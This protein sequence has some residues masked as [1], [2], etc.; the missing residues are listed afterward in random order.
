MTPSRTSPKTENLQHK[1]LAAFVTEAANYRHGK[2]GTN[3]GNVVEHGEKKR[4]WRKTPAD[5]VT[6]L[7]TKEA[8]QNGKGV[9]PTRAITKHTYG[10]PP[11][12]AHH[13]LLVVEGRAYDYDYAGKPGTPFADYMQ[14]MW[15]GTSGDLRLVAAPVNATTIKTLAAQPIS[16]DEYTRKLAPKVTAD[17]M[18]LFDQSPEWE[19]YIGSA[20][21]ETLTHSLDH[22]LSLTAPR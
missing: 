9:S 13:V 20:P 2:C 7:P 18:S 11:L 5:V 10:F 6:L 19:K 14:D 3:I 17:S 22:F 8:L 12:W 4:L 16:I 1:V 15:Q 21:E